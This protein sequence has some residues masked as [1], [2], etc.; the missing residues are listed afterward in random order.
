[1][2]LPALSRPRSEIAISVPAS[3]RPLGTNT[4]ASIPLLAGQRAQAR[5]HWDRLA[6]GEQA[7]L[8][9]I[10]AEDLVDPLDPDIERTAVLGDGFRVV[11]VADGERLAVRAQDRRHLGV[12]NVDRTRVVVDDAAAEPPALVAQRDE[13]RPVRGDANGRDA[14]EI[15]VR[16]AQHQAAAELQQTELPS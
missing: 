8:A 7:V 4:S 16:R 14:A 6:A 2:I 5:R 9:V 12:G 10:E 1:M 3:A 15:P 13:M 11:P